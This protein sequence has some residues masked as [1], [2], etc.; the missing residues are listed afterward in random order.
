[1]KKLARKALGVLL[2]MSISSLSSLALAE[3]VSPTAPPSFPTAFRGDWY[4]APGPCDRNRNTLALQIG[5]SSL[6][7]LDEFSGLLKR[8]V[9][10]SSRDVQYVA[11]YS[12][13]GHRWTAAETLRLSPKGS[14]L[15]LKPARTSSRY[16]RCSAD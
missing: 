7:Y 10:K 12:A 3:Q 11:E 5:V 9:R 14:Q 1:M 13:E 4:R 16:F 6:D 8:V 2:V 15:T